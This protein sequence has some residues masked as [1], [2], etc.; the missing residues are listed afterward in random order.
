M[1]TWRKA[2][3]TI[4][5]EGDDGTLSGYFDYDLGSWVAG[6]V[7]EIDESWYDV[8]IHIGPLHVS[9]VYWRLAP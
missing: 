5:G 7:L 2:S 3:F 6:V 1:N 9:F 8:S 4:F